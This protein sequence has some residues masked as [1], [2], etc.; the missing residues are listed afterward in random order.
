VNG[1]GVLLIL[2]AIMLL[3]TGF[4]FGQAASSS[5]TVEDIVGLL[6][7]KLPEQV[8][9][10]KVRANGKP[11]NLSTPE[12]VKLRNAGAGELLMIAMLDPGGA[13][14]TMPTGPSDKTGEVAPATPANPQ[15]GE[16]GVYYKKG[17]AWMEVLPEVV[18]WKTGGFLKNVASVGVVKKDVNG[19]IPGPNSR[20][21][22]AAPIE[23]TIYTPEGVAVTE[24]Q[25]IRLR[26]N[27]AKGYREF[28]TITGGVFNT[29]SGAERDMVPFEG[30]KVGNRLYSVLF[31]SNLGAGEYG[32]IC[33]SNSGG[34][35]GT[36]SL[37]MGKM[38]TF[39]VLE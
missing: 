38:Y 9:I 27:P 25:L 4:T 28:R 35:G 6:Q 12:L 21:S 20:N 29:K 24:Y 3:P 5:L 13:S 39:R 33:M 16:V 10:A 1:K 17:E 7:A 18:N 8:I 14:S 19:Y 37:S 32:F 26:N 11:F 30:K 31:P 34:A 15:F 23:F 2:T 22:I 36:Q